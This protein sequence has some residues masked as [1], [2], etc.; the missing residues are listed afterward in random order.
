VT[1][2]PVDLPVCEP[3]F[4]P[5]RLDDQIHR[6]VASEPMRALV[7]AYGKSLPE[8]GTGDLLAW[9]AAFSG[10][11][12]DFRRPGG[13]ERDQVTA[14][15]FGR[16]RTELIVA[17]AT[18]LGLVEP[19][20]P[21]SP[22]YRH[23]LVLG[24]LGRACL[25]RTQYAA[26][27]VLSGVVRTEE[28]A[29]LG[30]FRPLGDAEKQLPGLGEAVFEVD[31]LNVGVRAAFDRDRDSGRH[32]A[33]P[34]IQVLAAPPSEGRERAN[35]ADTYEF[36]ARRVRLRAP[37]RIL[38]V[39]SPIYVPFQHGDAIRILGLRY[40]CGI[41]TIGFDPARVTVP[42]APGATGPDRYLQEIHS[43][44]RSMRALAEAV[45]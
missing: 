32:P 25:Q 23:M 31:A 8:A 44:I 41:D 28:V 36:W 45:P 9:L 30:S 20:R 38:I 40:G 12:W 27:L 22:D 43:G 19:A 37:D 33:R 18:A 1:F 35:T 29:A 3:G 2:A 7:A 14:P 24:G 17:A 34:E 11:H 26:E 13:V 10:E 6:W 4:R 15:A 39:T 5:G 21:P 42:L 16:E